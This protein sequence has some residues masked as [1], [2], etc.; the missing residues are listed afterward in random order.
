MSLKMTEIQTLALASSI[1][2]GDAR[3]RPPKAASFPPESGN[4]MT[5]LYCLTVESVQHEGYYLENTTRFCVC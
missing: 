2:C 4:K 5:S 3:E 1:P